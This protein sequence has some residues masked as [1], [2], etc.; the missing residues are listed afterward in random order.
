[1][2]TE[3]QRRYIVQDLKA[4]FQNAYGLE[5]EHLVIPGRSYEAYPLAPVV[6]QITFVLDI[7]AVASFHNPRDVRIA[8]YQFDDEWYE[9][10]PKQR[11]WY[12]ILEFNYDPTDARAMHS[13]HDLIVT[14]LITQMPLREPE[15]DG[16]GHLLEEPTITSPA[17]WE[18]T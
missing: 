1:M 7:T 6:P 5:L 11:E 15:A 10:H 16:I 2:A 9:I 8:L 3:E 4:R 18:Y 14:S 13:A 17:L 12:F